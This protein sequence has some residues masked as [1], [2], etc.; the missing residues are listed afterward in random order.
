MRGII[1]ISGKQTLRLVEQ[2]FQPE[3]SPAESSVKLSIKP[4]VT[5]QQVIGQPQERGLS[6]KKVAQRVMG[7][8]RLQSKNSVRSVES[9]LY[10]WPG[11]RSYTREPVAE[12]HTVGSLPLLEMLVRQICCA[13][14]RLAE[15]G[16]FTLRAF[17]AGRIDLTQAEAVLGVIDATDAVSLQNALTQLAGGIA[18]P[19]LQIREELLMV[20]AELEA[21]LD[22]VE[23]DI[24]FIAPEVVAAKIT[25]GIQK[26]SEIVSQL[27]KRSF[28]QEKP[29]V[30][31]L[32]PP[33]AGKSSLFNCL[34]CQGGTTEEAFDRTE[35]IVSATRGTTRDYVCAEILVG[36]LLCELVDTAGLDETFN[37]DQSRDQIQTL[38]QEQTDA[39]YQTATLKLVCLEAEAVFCRTLS[40][41][42]NAEKTK[43]QLSSILPLLKAQEGAFQTA[44]LL[45]TKSDQL[46]AEELQ[47][48]LQEIKKQVRSLD[49]EQQT[50]FLETLPAISNAPE[51]SSFSEPTALEPTVK[52]MGVS[53]LTGGDFK[54]LLQSIST[55]LELLS[56]SEE[57][58]SVA[59]TAVRCL[60]SLRLADEYLGHAL[61]AAQEGFGEEIVAAEIRN[62]L[63]ELGKVAGA[64]YTDD[65]LD[66]I[67]S[68]FCI[69]K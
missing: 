35:A 45:V 67:F 23:E 52:V 40:T 33:N 57:G 34:L 20:L 18:R 27:S 63:N 29:T 16:E 49:C 62:S 8:L 39:Q 22:F 69:G 38:A 46:T 59:G 44:L 2:F 28:S 14:A 5:E 61:E 53:S 50:A 10:L 3:E 51:K 37:R 4:P 17:L 6:Q 54:E 13:G 47:G 24:E 25:N 31:L 41:K 65:I 32:G 58:G 43:V 12:L 26:I 48:V 60:E 66:R 68:S 30:V 36:S 64:V 56:V 15:P 9:A 11:Q 7:R 55:E 1:R 19:L 21:G 42:E